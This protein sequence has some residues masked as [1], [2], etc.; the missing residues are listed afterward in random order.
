MTQLGNDCVN[1]F[2]TCVLRRASIQRNEAPE[3]GFCTNSDFW[4]AIAQTGSSAWMS[5]R[6]PKSPFEKRGSSVLMSMH[7]RW[8]PSAHNFLKN[9]DW[10]IVTQEK[11]KKR[12]P[13]WQWPAKIFVRQIWPY[14]ARKDTNNAQ[15][16]T[17]NACTVSINARKV[18]YR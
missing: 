5:M 16:D 8:S 9:T 13:V 10:P 6:E 15:N 18:F 17:S 7:K 14:Y 12:A 11:D 4:W 3:A 2:L 1:T